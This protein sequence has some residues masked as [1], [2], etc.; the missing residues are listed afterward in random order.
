MRKIAA[1]LSAIFAFFLCVFGAGCIE[2]KDIKV[3]IEVLLAAPEYGKYTQALKLAQ[4]AEPDVAARLIQQIRDHYTSFMKQEIIRRYGTSL[5]AY[6]D[7]DGGLN[8]MRTDGSART[9][10]V[11]QQML[12][13]QCSRAR[14]SPNGETLAFTTHVYGDTD[15]EL[16]VVQRDGSGLAALSDN[17]AEEQDPSWAPD[18]QSLV[19]TVDDVIFTLNLLTGNKKR[20]FPPASIYD[21]RSAYFPFWDKSGTSLYFVMEK[22]LQILTP[23]SEPEHLLIEKP[24]NDGMSGLLS[25]YEDPEISPDGHSLVVFYGSLYFINL[26]TLQR[27][28]FVYGISPSWSPDGKYILY[29]DTG[30]GLTDSP[31]TEGLYL[32][33]VAKEERV[34]PIYIGPGRL[35]SWSPEIPALSTGKVR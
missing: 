20:I 10:I 26:D 11:T 30:S 16:F 21:S 32:L 19:Y 5:I 2:K 35:P 22:Q 28:R 14:W 27:E 8:T 33:P 7:D 24:V 15:S 18:G 25:T 3:Q 12:Y 31:V 9:A 1:V 23:G 29:Y 17:N 4:S 34:F 13:G 6:V